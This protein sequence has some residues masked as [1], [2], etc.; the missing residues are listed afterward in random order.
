MS[1]E[2]RVE[3]YALL[4]QGFSLRDIA[5]RLD[6]SHTSLSRELKRHTRYGR[7]YKPVLANKRAAIW[8]GRQRYKAPLK[9]SE[10]FRYVMD[11]LKQR[12]S[13]QDISGRIS[14]DHPELSIC[15]E[16]IYS[17]IYSRKWRKHKLWKYLDSGHLKRR[18]KHGRKVLSYT[19]V[20]DTKSIDLRP[21]EANFRLELGHK[22]T[23][24]VEGSRNDTAA[25]SVTA[26]RLTRTARLVKVKDKT[27][28]EKIK[29]LSRP[30]PDKAYWKTVTAD[31][32]PENKNYLK[33]EQKLNITVFFCHPYHSW[34][35]G[36]VE[37]INRYIR[38]F[39]PKGEDIGKYSW[40]DIQ[41]IEDWFN[42]K[43]LKCCLGRDT[44][45]NE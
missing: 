2:E 34:E 5:N 8:A 25:L 27:G 14:I 43:P 38:K 40:R 1:I 35:K 10:T 18:Q 17:W 16:S 21:N 42:N 3:L 31:R 13:P 4:K 20:M 44:F 23:D 45:R 22:E 39:I 19:E 30:A 36:T 41:R 15:V 9:N 6:R 11:K 32:G 7:T 29:A 28:R 24:L 37:R 26:D 33:W 12:W